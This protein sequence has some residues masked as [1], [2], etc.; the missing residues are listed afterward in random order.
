MPTTREV[1]V[2]NEK[3][4]RNRGAGKT[5][6]RGTG[7]LEVEV[8]KSQKKKEK[9]TVSRRHGKV[10]AGLNQRKISMEKQSH[11]PR[12]RTILQQGAP[13]GWKGSRQRGK[14]KRTREKRNR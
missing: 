11:T 9:W 13:A 3:K 6:P 12:G 10:V 1:G 2:E 14:G 5:I 4:S 7:I 8:E